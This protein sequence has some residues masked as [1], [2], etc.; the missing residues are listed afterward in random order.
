MQKALLI[1]TALLLSAGWISGQ[2]LSESRRSAPNAYIYKL[3]DA[4]MAAFAADPWVKTDTT[5]F[6]HLVDSF[7]ADSIYQRILPP[8][9]Y[10]MVR[11]HENRIRLSYLQAPT[12]YPVLVNNEMDLVIRVTTID[13]LVISDAQVRIKGKKIPYDTVLQAYRLPESGRDGVLEIT[14]MGITAW[15]RVDARFRHPRFRRTLRDLPNTPVVNY[16]WIPVRFVG[17]I[18]IHIYRSVEYGYPVGIVQRLING[19]S[20]CQCLLDKNRCYRS[21]DL[22]SRKH[23]G[24]LVFNKP[25][26]HPE[27][28]VF[29]K[30]FVI[31]DRS[32]KPAGKEALVSIQT[33][34]V[35]LCIDTIRAYRKG[36]YTGY[37]VISDTMPLKLDR[38]YSLELTTK[39]RKRSYISNSFRYED[40]VLNGLSLQLTA[41][42]AIHYHGQP[43]YL[44]ADAKDE[45]RLPLKQGRFEVIIKRR[46]WIDF[47]GSEPTFLYDT[48]ASFAHKLTPEGTNRILISDTTFPVVNVSY[49]AEVTLFAAD[50]QKVVKSSFV[51]Y[52]QTRK[53]AAIELLEDSVLF[54]YKV[55]GI[56]N[57]VEGQIFIT[58]IHQPEVLVY[59]GILPHS[60]RFDP[61]VLSYR[62]QANGEIIT[63]KISDVADAM[64]QCSI[65]EEGQ[66]QQ[67]KI[68]NPRKLPLTWFVYHKNREIDRG[69]GEAA[70]VNLK[71]TGKKYLT[72]KVHYTVAGIDGFTDAR[73]LRN[74]CALNVQITAPDVVYPGQK[75]EV[76][77]RVTDPAGK[78]VAGA[79]ITAYGLNANFHHQSERPPSYSCRL[80]TLH[81]LNRYSMF[82][83][84]EYPREIPLDYSRWRDLAG[85]AT[86][87]WY[88]LT[89]PEDGMAMERFVTTENITQVSPWLVRNGSFL[90]PRAIYIDH[91]PVWV[92]WATVHNPMAFKVYDGRHNFRLV[93]KDA[94]YSFDTLITGKG[95]H[96]HLSFD[97]NNPP[98]ALKIEKADPHKMKA[99]LRSLQRMT[100]VYESNVRWNMRRSYL[101]QGDRVWDVSSSD[102]FSYREVVAPLSQSAS[103]F[104]FPDSS[105]I[106]FQYKPDYRYDAQPGLLVL[107]S[108]NHQELERLTS[109]PHAESRS[110]IGEQ[111]ITLNQLRAR[112]L[113]RIRASLPSRLFVDF[114]SFNPLK[115]GSLV[116][117]TPFTHEN[118]KPLLLF[119]FHYSSS[120][121]AG[122][123]GG[124]ENTIE[125]LVPGHYALMYLFEDGSYALYDS[126]LVKP[127][128][129]S[130]HPLPQTPIHSIDTLS[131]GALEILQRLLSG[132]NPCHLEMVPFLTHSPHGSSLL[133]Q[134]NADQSVLEGYVLSSSLEPIPFANI[135]INNFS[136]G[137]ISDSSGYYRIKVPVASFDLMVTY[138]GFETLMVKGAEPGRMNLILEESK[139]T[140]MSIIM[141]YSAHIRSKENYSSSSV[142]YAGSR[143][144]FGH[145]YY[146]D[147]VQTVRAREL[148]RLP[149]ATGNIQYSYIDNPKKMNINGFSAD[150]IYD[151]SPF[152]G[153][154]VNTT[155]EAHS[156]LRQDFSDY[157]FWEPTLKTDKRGEVKFQVT[158]PDDI[159]A[160]DTWFLVM[161][162][163]RQTGFQ[164]KTIRAYKPL[165]A[166]LH[167]PRFLVAGDTAR[168]IGTVT[169]QGSDTVMI[170]RRFAQSG[171]QVFAEHRRFLHHHTDSFRVTTGSTD[172][173]WLKYT[174]HQEDGYFDGE[175]RGIPVIPGGMEE[176]TGQ[177]HLLHQGE[178][179]TLRFDTT[180]GEVRL[181]VM[182]DMPTFIRHELKPLIEYKYECNE[183]LAS[184]LMALLLQRELETNAM[185]KA[186][187]MR[188]I[189]RTIEQ[190]ITN[191]NTQGL[192]GWWK[193][194]PTTWWITEHV[195]SAMYK[196]KTAGVMFSL[197]FLPIMQELYRE[198]DHQTNIDQKLLILKCI[199]LMQPAIQ[200]DILLALCTHRGEM[201]PR[202]QFRLWELEQL[203]GIPVEPDSVLRY[204]QSSFTGEAW[205]GRDSLA[206]NPTDDALLS[207][208]IAL[209]VLKDAS[210]S[211]DTTIANVMHWLLQYP[212]HHH[213]NTYT[214]A[215]W[216]DAL[217]IHHQ[218]V[219][220][221]ATPP[222]VVI[223]GSPDQTISTFPFTTTLSSDA[224]LV[225]K[226]LSF[227]R[228]FVSTDQ[229]HQVTDPG[230][231]NQG[232]SVETRFDRHDSVMTA[233]REI[234]LWVDVTVEKGASYVMI[235]VPIPAGC[236]YGEPNKTNSWEA[237][238]EQYKEGTSIFC[239]R[240]PAGKHTF[241]IPLLPR[242]PGSYSLN[243]ARAEMMYFPVFNG[244]SEIKRVKVVPGT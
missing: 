22:F 52:Y 159:T 84:D 82:T 14:H 48:L 153:T 26:Y 42:T 24:Y 61:Y 202:Q 151:F 197:P 96:T 174:I 131:Q 109:E 140:E 114:S 186:A 85:L 154:V 126:L 196:A 222:Q 243:P 161:G 18:P 19:I 230:M 62:L 13:G 110:Q 89:Y 15:Y 239:E 111:V 189:N 184:R 201:K 206:G 187:N 163:K 157:A 97:I 203:A 241:A 8:G 43:F 160:W 45:N 150:T 226:S 152:R 215:L 5:W 76:D 179:V 234:T 216:V 134:R 219:S 194:S 113:E 137:T 30:A 232:F 147:G 54:S 233:G 176:I 220:G 144:Q 143:D 235:E 166:Q 207:T 25:K 107:T 169:N 185:K 221:A 2:G 12:F 20:H 32:G 73:L 74:E 1:A 105:I 139:M 244:N 129:I 183:Q 177:L 229:R 37:F 39:R 4:H 128:C 124:S 38:Q 99:E 238:R 121:W 78:P 49:E 46:G 104:I 63:R 66:I 68:L 127:A 172:S 21:D 50:N 148:Q 100:M 40:Y 178:E 119:L 212:L 200:P 227:G 130:F 198:Y 168:V 6:R 205:F 28:T 87:S 95:M 57:E 91:Q 101:T 162:G 67:V 70:K 56:R 33:Y 211:S 133:S 138:I 44:E 145:K 69:S 188:R 210:I 155:P 83:M 146:V 47:P 218:D 23:S 199:M 86:I 106:Q 41:P 17:R 65:F 237:W 167:L 191:R 190:L 71:Y 136:L 102:R 103:T 116:V 236:V 53:E 208:R 142:S 228:V 98:A 29:Y 108:L 135:T 59:D 72:V 93:T 125:K 75:T 149:S 16:V 60:L 225:I 94:I 240:L 9:H 182:A 58:K 88:R 120:Q 224:E 7:P 213:L 171:V 115:N 175:L 10:M 118:S 27:D 193:S 112:H 195:F 158:F 180:K 81:Y 204:L 122:M 92:D 31:R 11:I 231:R 223:T 3:D 64:V 36:A 209:K 214:R 242:F 77:I 217:M 51:T 132:K 181:Q 35:S 117:N 79:D 165:M 123:S 55:N 34:P 141:G 80:I 90:T 170:E 156:S 164:L 173:L 192:W